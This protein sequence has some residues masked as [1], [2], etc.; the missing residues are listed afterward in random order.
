MKKKLLFTIGLACILSIN[1][2]TQTFPNAGFENWEVVGVTVEDPV[3]WSSANEW[4]SF[5]LPQLIFK[6]TDA[7]TGGFALHAISDTATIP[8]PFGN[9]VLDT[10]GGILLVGPLNFDYPGI[11]YTDRPTD[12][13]AWVKGTVANGDA[14]LIMAELSKWDTNTNSRQEVGSA[15]YAMTS[16]V[17][18]YSE[19]TAPFDYSLPDTPDTLT[20]AIL[21][22]N[23]GPGGTVMPGNE[24]FVDDISLSVPVGVNEID[25]GNSI[26]TYPNPFENSA[27]LTFENSRN[28]THTLT[29]FDTQGRI[30]RTIIGIHSDRVEIERQNLTGGMYFFQ[31]STDKRVVALG[32]LIIK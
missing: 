23:A 15:I 20:L 13:K 2:T 18:N 25:N 31:L 11:P 10:V 6:S 29:L 12:M 30:M 8:P 4:E 5:G 27:T 22:G 14:C 24:F 1:A 19:I 32:K 7:H 3:G 28:I 17:G 16:S 9:G 26:N 21:A